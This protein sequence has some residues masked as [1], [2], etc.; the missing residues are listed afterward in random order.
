MFLDINAHLPINKKALKAYIKCSNS[1]AGHGHPSSLTKPS[2][3]ANKMLES[4]REKIAELIGAKSSNQII[5]TYGASQSCKWGLKIFGEAYVS[6]IEHPAIKYLTEGYPLLYCDKDCNITLKEKSICVHMQN[7]T[8]T[9]Q[10]FSKFKGKLFSDISQSLGKTKI[11]INEFDIAA[12]G[13]HKFGGPGGT[14]FLYLKNTDDWQPYENY[15]Y[16]LDRPG[17]PDVPGMV[18]M[19][20]ALEEAL[21]SLDERLYNMKLFQTKIENMFESYGLE[22]IA[23]NSNRSFSTSLIGGFKDSHKLLLELN[24]KGIYIGLGSAC[25][26][27]NIEKSPLM[28][29]LGKNYNINNIIRISNWGNYGEKEADI[30]INIFKEIWTSLKL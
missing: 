22:I 4:A 23:K 2:L 12:A 6:P 7:E 5:F 1:M 21:K 27:Y 26:S 18:G 17:T 8:G 3:K 30:F 29:I 16:Y 15:G 25:S 11:N 20:I 24:K 28:D 13:G 14:G 9:I 10:D 19:S